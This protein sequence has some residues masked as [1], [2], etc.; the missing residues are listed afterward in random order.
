MLEPPV[1]EP[2]G[3][4]LLVF[5]FAILF[6]FYAIGRHAELPTRLSMAAFGIGTLVLAFLAYRLHQSEVNAC[7]DSIEVANGGDKYSCLE[8][9][10]LFAN[11]LAELF[12]V[13][14]ELGLA[15]M[16]AGGLIHWWKER[17]VALRE[18][19]MSVPTQPS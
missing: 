13:V 11:A 8:P 17:R 19:K 4:W 9:G 3:L 14:M 15:A 10:N 5:P 16:A 1:P 18:S 7:K 12:L 6:G 2:E